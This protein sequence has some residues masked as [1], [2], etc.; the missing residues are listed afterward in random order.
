MQQE[1]K[2]SSEQSQISRIWFL[3]PEMELRVKTQKHN[4][5]KKLENVTFFRET[6][7][8]D[9]ISMNEI[10]KTYKKKPKIFAKRFP[11]FAGNPANRPRQVI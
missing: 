6:K 10:Q 3:R 1:R 9:F 5:E 2:D 11:H 7:M 8:L 4:F